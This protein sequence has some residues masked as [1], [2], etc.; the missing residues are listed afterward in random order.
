MTVFLVETFIVKPD[1]L[2]EWMTNH[3]KFL[4]WMKKHPDLFKEIKSLKTF[5][6]MFGGNWGGYVEMWE[7]KSVSDI[8]KVMSRVMQNKEYMTK[9]YP[10]AM[11]LVVPG[12]Y[13]ENIWN[14]VI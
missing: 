10:E 8:E 5:S 13:S 7:A 4:A 2:E 3:K 9:L 14:F 12:T 6:Q 1:K 11:A